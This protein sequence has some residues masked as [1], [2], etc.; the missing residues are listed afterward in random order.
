MN[1]SPAEK[2]VRNCT[3]RYLLYFA[4]TIV[5]RKEAYKEE[6]KYSVFTTYD[7]F[8]SN[9]LSEVKEHRDI[10]LSLISDINSYILYIVDRTNLSIIQSAKKFSKISS[11]C[12][13]FKADSKYE[14]SVAKYNLRTDGKDYIIP[15]LHFT[16]KNKL[17][18]LDFFFRGPNEVP[19]D[20]KWDDGEYDGWLQFR[21]GDGKNAISK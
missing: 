5:K 19:P 11:I 16:W 14:R 3:N 15:V 7:V 21:W 4:F 17:N 13:Y 6:I 1:Y 8:S 12:E 10:L 2:E 9:S 18:E 20:Y